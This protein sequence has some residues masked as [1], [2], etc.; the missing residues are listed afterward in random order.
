MLISHAAAEKKALFA[1]AKIAKIGN[2]FLSCLLCAL[3]SA[4]HW[5]GAIAKK[6]SGRYFIDI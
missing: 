1:A 2:I 5:F 4:R 3:R 6:F